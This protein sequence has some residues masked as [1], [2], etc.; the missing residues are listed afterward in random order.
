MNLTLQQQISSS[1]YI[2]IAY[3]GT[4]S[5]HIESNIQSNQADLLLPPSFSVSPVSPGPTCHDAGLLHDSNPS[6][7]NPTVQDNKVYYNQYPCLATKNYYQ[8]LEGSNNYN[9]LQTK[10]EK[11]YSSGTSLIFS[12][13]WEKLLGYGSDSNLFAASSYRAP[14]VPGFGMKGEYGNIPFESTNVV[15]AGG[16]WAVPF[17]YGQAFG[18]RKGLIDTLLGGWKF[19]GIFT[20]QSGQPVSVS[21]STTHANSMGCNAL[22]DRT[23]LDNSNRSVDHWFNASAFSDPAGNVT[24]PNN[25]DFS[26]LGSSPNQV[27]GPA[28]HRGDL[29]VQKIFHFTGPNELQ[30]RAES[31]NIT[32]TPNFGQPGTL[33]PTNTAFASIT[34]TRDAPSDARE[35][36]FALKYI[37]GHGHQ[38]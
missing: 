27:Y 10:Y 32:N 18:N 29:G 4:Q 3:V 34:N 35:M 36:Q 26:P 5:R 14:L 20:Y 31:F 12:Y 15:H 2:Q 30:F 24:T 9:S 16:I 17:G 19:T 1:Q 6:N 13:T 25:S 38:E 21:C 8:W 11:L 7:P 28:F 23:R 33:T 22:T 37:F